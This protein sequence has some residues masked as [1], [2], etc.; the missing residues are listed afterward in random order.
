MRVG[1]TELEAIAARTLEDYN[2]NADA[3]RVGTQ[4]HDVSQN[5]AALLKHIR[6]ASPFVLLDFGCG[7]G[8]DLKT[9]KATGHSPIGVD[10]SQRFVAPAREETACEGWQHDVLRRALP[11]QPFDGATANADP[12]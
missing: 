11:G 5:I 2:R 8:R 10:G 9:L 6:G 1:K 3:F 7:P 4:D 12:Y